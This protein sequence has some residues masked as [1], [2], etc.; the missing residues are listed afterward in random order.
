VA[1]KKPKTESKPKRGFSTID[2]GDGVHGLMLV[3]PGYQW[4]SIGRHV[5]KQLKLTDKLKFDCE[6]GMFVV[7][8]PDPAVLAKLQAKLDP[9]L[10]D[11]EV[12]KKMIAKLGEA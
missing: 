3:G 9:I 7:R 6:G 10:A 5:A 2:Y 8:S 1:T 12:F 4:E 11:R